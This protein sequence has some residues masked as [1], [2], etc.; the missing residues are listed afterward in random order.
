MSL[1]TGHCTT[2]TKKINKHVSMIL[3]N[4]TMKNVSA[5]FSLS[6]ASALAATYTYCIVLWKCRGNAWY[7]TTHVPRTCVQS[8]PA[9]RY[10]GWV[11]NGEDRISIA[12]WRVGSPLPRCSKQNSLTIIFNFLFNFMSFRDIA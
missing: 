6:Y 10:R 2:S 12:Q 9:Y 3:S 11:S 1:D 4:V 7:W 8:L 5:V